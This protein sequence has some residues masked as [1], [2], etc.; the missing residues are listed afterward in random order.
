MVIITLTHT[1]NFLSQHNKRNEIIL[2]FYNQNLLHNSGEIADSNRE[3]PQRKAG[4]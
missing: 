4:Q 3:T 2:I 1:A